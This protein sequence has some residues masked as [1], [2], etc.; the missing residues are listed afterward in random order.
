M[1]TQQDNQSSQP[2]DEQRDDGKKFNNLYEFLHFLIA[3]KQGIRFLLSV[4][5]VALSLAIAGIYFLRPEKIEITTGLGKV[6]I[7]NGD[8]QNTVFLL[9]P[10]GGDENDPW[11]KTG[12]EIKEGDVI[13]I[14]ASGRVNTALKRIVAQTI[15]PGIDEPTWVGPSGLS[16]SQ[17][18]IYFKAN[19]QS[20]VL[21]DKDN[22][23]YGFGM[24]LAAVKDSKDVV[25]QEDI[26]PFIKNSNYIKFTAKYD[27]KLVLTV[28]DIWLDGG[29]KDTYVPPFIEDNI[30]HY[31]QLA[32]YEAAFKEDFNSWSE[33]EELEKAQEQYQRRLK[34]WETIKESSNWNIWYDDNIG[35]FSVSITVNPEA[36]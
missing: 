33:E 9:S 28:N 16:R 20:K 5:G 15:V 29:M 8:T 19:D 10:N 7:K 36:E 23:Y 11:V 14:T 17:N 32:K 12:I 13:K 6:T 2:P 34:G 21:P 35:A 18:R 22:T 31:L 27:G 3:D 26:I 1:L 25:Q 4:L 24:L 30:Q